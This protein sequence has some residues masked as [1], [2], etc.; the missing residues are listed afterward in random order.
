VRA[1]LALAVLGVVLLV[2]CA[3]GSEDEAAPAEP[4]WQRIEPRGSTRCARGGKYAFWVRRADPKRVL[5]FFQGGGGCFSAETCRP[6]STWFDDRVDAY[7]DP[8]GSGGILDFGSSTSP[9][10]PGTSIPARASCATGRCASTR[11]A[12]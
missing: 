5:I 11:R 8:A 12:F 7:D 10:A 6:G 4:T 3:G 9:P 2:A 1:P